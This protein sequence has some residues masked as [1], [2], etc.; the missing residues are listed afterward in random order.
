VSLVRFFAPP[1]RGD[2]DALIDAFLCKP[3]PV[4][5]RSG[6]TMLPAEAA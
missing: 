4:Q 1:N 5:E 2:L 3:E 6:N